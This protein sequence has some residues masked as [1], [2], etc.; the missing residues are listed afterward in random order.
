LKNA[1]KS[2]FQV[3]RCE[4]ASL[5]VFSQ[6]VPRLN[7]ERRAPPVSAC[8]SGGR[9]RF[10][11]PFASVPCVSRLKNVRHIRGAASGLSCWGKRLAR[12]VV[13][14]VIA[15][16]GNVIQGVAREG[17]G[18][19]RR[20]FS[21]VISGEG[22]GNSLPDIHNSSSEIYISAFDLH[23]WLLDLCISPKEIHKCMR[24]FGEEPRSFPSRV[25][26]GD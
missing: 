16:R 17:L 6:G 22:I 21:L 19:D 18:V 1:Q 23:K 5:P 26:I 12:H 4:A 10:L 14:Q 13:R 15:R 11:P 3:E 9:V 25:T 7:E 20:V 24:E 8:F 2:S